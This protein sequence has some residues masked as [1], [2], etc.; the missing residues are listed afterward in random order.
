MRF[1]AFLMSV[2]LLTPLLLTSCG[3]GSAPHEIHETMN[4]IHGADEPVDDP[5][6]LVRES[7]EAWLAAGLAAYE[8]GKAP[9]DLKDFFADSANMTYLTLYDHMLFYDSE[10]AVPVAE[11]LFAFI[12]EQ[13]G[14]DALLDIEKR[15]E[16]KS[17][18][19]SSLGLDMVYSQAEEVEAFFSS[20]DFSSDEAY[21][22][23][24]SFDNVSYYFKDFDKGTP[25]QYHSFLY[26]STT[27]LTTMIEYLKEQKLDRYFDTEREFRY[28]VTL[29]TGKPSVTAYDT[30]NMYINDSSTTLHEAVHAM[31]ITEKNNIWLSEGICNYLGKCLG[32]HGQVVTAHMQILTMAERGYYD[33]RASAG[34]PT[35][36]N[37]KKLYETYTAHGGSLTSIDDF[38]FRLLADASAWVELQTEAYTTLGT[39]YAYINNKEYDGTGAEFSYD[40]TSS[41]LF[42]LADAYGLETILHAYETQNIE[43][44]F[45]K[46]YEGLKADWLLYLEDCFSVQ[47]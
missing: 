22:Y 21:K 25:S 14:A 26:F 23:I 33:K 17:A 16:Y 20:M 18:F 41:L 13:Y 42:Y 7:G 35:A 19:L 24:L 37:I 40:Q 10:K 34:D 27:G 39:S 8:N 11:A 3:I 9:A 12:Y 2:F 47:E 30:G 36:I 31:G 5:F 1:L 38:D 43:D 46:T 32:F 44:T 15:C 6:A 4:T 45:G 28:Y 29:E